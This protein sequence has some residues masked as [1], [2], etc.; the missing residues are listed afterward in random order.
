MPERTGYIYRRAAAKANDL[1]DLLIGVRRGWAWT[2][3]ALVESTDADL[4]VDG[5]EGR[6]CLARA[7][8][9]WRCGKDEYD[10]LLLALDPQPPAGF[11]PLLPNG[12]GS[13]EPWH[14]QRMPYMIHRLRGGGDLDDDL[15]A[16]GFIAPGGS[17]QFVALMSANV[18]REAVR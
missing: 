15:A 1:R 12:R 4:L 5:A 18:P 14:V 6:A 8:L 2:P 13:A 10:L 3:A 11:T 7:E 9:R 17:V 16:F